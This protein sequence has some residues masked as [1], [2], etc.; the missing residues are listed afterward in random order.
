MQ[1]ISSSQLSDYIIERS[2]LSMSAGNMCQQSEIF[3]SQLNCGVRRG[4]PL[5]G[6]GTVTSKGPRDPLS[7]LFLHSS[8]TVHCGPALGEAFAFAA[9][10]GGFHSNSVVV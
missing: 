4:R 1:V 7:F 6:G 10:S 3:E 5:D 8:S 2:N 9:E